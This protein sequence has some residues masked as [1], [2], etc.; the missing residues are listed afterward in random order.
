MPAAALRVAVVQAGSVLFDTPASLAKLRRL[1]A[2]AAGEG[3]RLA[4]F[5]EA[6]LG[7]Y[8]K[9]VDFG[10]RVGSRSP[11]GR[12]WFRRYYEAAIDVPGPA[13]EALAEVARETGLHLVVGAIE[14]EGGTLY[15]SALFVSPAAGLLGKH[16]KLVPTA[17]ERLVWGAGDGST[18]P[19]LATPVGRLG[20]AICWEN[21]MPLFRTAMYAQGVELYCA[22]TVDDREGWVAT[23]RHVALEG[24]CFVL[25]A[26]QHL[27]RRDC[28]PDYEPIQGGAPETELIRGGSLVVGPLG[29]VLAGPVYGRE[30]VL[31]ADLDLGDIAR[32]KFDLDVVGH[33]ARP[34]VFRLHVDRSPKPAV[35][36]GPGGPDGGRGG[37][38]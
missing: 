9:G 15:C 32:G 22:P 29:Q 27:L 31:V 19:V 17:M 38:T 4:V 26:C 34:D 2:E 33:Y 20:A 5:P 16:R 14:R 1:A 28:P 35:T 3:A 13:A 23:M 25:S 37:A 6:F 18:M 7:G 24:R 36:F 21:Y 12:D 30:A 8:P 11:E 10:A